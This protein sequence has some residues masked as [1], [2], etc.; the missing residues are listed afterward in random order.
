MSVHTAMQYNYQQYTQTSGPQ[1]PV[2][3]VT[4]ATPVASSFAPL[5]GSNPGQFGKPRFETLEN[6]ATLMSSILAPGGSTP[7]YSQAQAYL[8]NSRNSLTTI[9]QKVARLQDEIPKM[10]ELLDSARIKLSMLLDQEREYTEFIRHFTPLSSPPPPPVEEAH[11]YSSL[12]ADYMPHTQHNPSR[13]YPVVPMTRP[14]IAHIEHRSFNFSPSWTHDL[15]QVSTHAAISSQSK[16]IKFKIDHS[17]IDNLLSTTPTSKQDGMGELINVCRKDFCGTLTEFYRNIDGGNPLFI[18]GLCLENRYGAK[19]VLIC[20]HRNAKELNRFICSTMLNFTAEMHFKTSTLSYRLTTGYAPDGQGTGVDWSLDFVNHADFDSE[21]FDPKSTVRD[22]RAT[23][24]KGRKRTLEKKYTLFF[25]SLEE[26]DKMN[27]CGDLFKDL[28]SFNTHL[29]TQGYLPLPLKHVPESLIMDAF[30]QYVAG[31][32]LMN[33]HKLRRLCEERDIEKGP[34]M[35]LPMSNSTSQPGVHLRKKL[36]KFYP[37]FYYNDVANM[38]AAMRTFHAHMHQEPVNPHEDLVKQNALA[39]LGETL[40]KLFQPAPRSPEEFPLTDVTVAPVFVPPKPVLPPDPTISP[41]S[42]ASYIAH[43]VSRSVNSAVDTVTERAH[44]IGSKFGK[45]AVAGAFDQFKTIIAEAI[46]TVRT[47]LSAGLASLMDTIKANKHLII[48][49]C[50][51]IL[52]AV[53]GFAF[54]KLVVPYWFPPKT[55][56]ILVEAHFDIKDIFSIICGKTAENFVD[57]TKIDGKGVHGSTKDFHTTGFMSSI[58]DASSIV[59]LLMNCDKIAITFASYVKALLDWSATKVTS[60]PFFES[61][62][63]ILNYQDEIKSMIST[64]DVQNYDTL[65]QKREFVKTYERLV[66]CAQVLF[67]IDIPLYAA[68]TNVVFRLQPVF[69]QLKSHICTEMPRQKPLSVWFAGLTGVGKTFAT[70]ELPKALFGWL[71]RNHPESFAEIGMSNYSEGLVL[72]RRF[73]NE[74]W[75]GYIAN[76]HWVVKMDDIFQSYKMEDRGLEA[77]AVISIV[78]DAAYAL[79]MAAIE[80]KASTYFL[81][82]VLLMSSN[83]TEPELDCIGI[84]SPAAFRRRRDFII[85]VLPRPGHLKNAD[86]AFT[87][88]AFESMRF[89]VKQLNTSTM[90]FSQPIVFD[91]LA[92]WLKLVADIGK[93]YVFH[94]D[95]SKH[96]SN[97]I[98]YSNLFEISPEYTEYVDM[99]SSQIKQKLPDKTW[100]P[101]I[102]T[103]EQTTSTTTAISTAPPIEGAGVGLDL[104]VDG[105]MEG[106]NP[107]SNPG[108][109]SKYSGNKVYP[110][111]HEE[112]LKRE[113]EAIRNDIYTPPTR[114]QK[115]NRF[116][117]K[118]ASTIWKNKNPFVASVVSQLMPLPYW[119]LSK[120]PEIYDPIRTTSQVGHPLLQAENFSNYRVAN[121]TDLTLIDWVIDFTPPIL[122]SAEEV[123]QT[124]LSWRNTVNSVLNIPF[125]ATFAEYDLIFDEIRLGNQGHDFYYNV[126][127]WNFMNNPT[128]DH[129]VIKLMTRHASLAECRIVSNGDSYNRKR[130]AYIMS[131]PHYPIAMV[132][133]MTKNTLCSAL[134]KQILHQR[135]VPLVHYK[136]MYNMRI[137]LANMGCPIRT[138]WDTW[139]H[140]APRVPEPIAPI[141]IKKVVQ[142]TSLTLSLFATIAASVLLY[143]G[144]CWAIIQI[145]TMLIVF[146]CRLFGR[147]KK[148]K[149]LIVSGH[150]DEKYQA[151]LAKL[152]RRKTPIIPHADGSD[153]IV[154]EAHGMQSVSDLSS[155]FAYNT[156]LAKF[157]FTTGYSFLGFMSSTGRG[158]FAFPRHY[159]IPGTLRSIE[160]S[161]TV[162]RPLEHLVMVAE[163]KHFIMHEFEDRDLVLCFI[164]GIQ[165]FRNLQSHLRSRK[166]PSLEGVA[167]TARIDILDSDTVDAVFGVVSPGMIHHFTGKRIGTQVLVDGMN[168]PMT[169]HSE[170]LLLS[171]LPSMKK[172]CGLFTMCTNDAIQKKLLGINT[173]GSGD[174]SCT[175]PIY[176]E[177]LELMEQK[178]LAIRSVSDITNIAHCAIEFADPLLIPCCPIVEK[179]CTGFYEGM[180]VFSLIDKAGNFPQKTSLLPTPV[181]T[182]QMRLNE[183]IPPPYEL[184]TAPAKLRTTELIDPL[185]LSFRKEKGR[186]LYFGLD[187]F[188]P[189]YWRG[190]FTE[191]FDDF[192]YRILTLEEAINGI[193]HLGNFHGIALNTASGHPWSQYGYQRS[194]LIVRD[195]PTP[196]VFPY[197][198]GTKPK[199]SMF[200]ERKG[201]I[202]LWVHPDLQTS[203]YMMFYHASLGLVTPAYFLYCL[204]DETRPLDRVNLGY[205]RG[206]AMGSVHH[207]I[208]C[209]MVF[210]LIFSTL[211]KGVDHD[212]CVSV[213]PFSSHWTRI[214]ARL[215]QFG[216]NFVSHDVEAYD[217]NF[218]VQT[219]APALLYNFALTFKLKIFG[220]EYYCL[221]NGT[222]STFTG[223]YVIR[224]I[225]VIRMNQPS[226]GYCTTVYNSMANS[227]KGRR[228]WGEVSTEPF[229]L[230]V[231][232]IVGGDDSVVSV[233]TE[234]VKIFNGIIISKIAKRLF[235]HTHT[236]STKGPVIHPFDEP[237]STV[238]YKRPFT[239]LKGIFIAPLDPVTLESMTQWIQKPRNGESF[240]TQ[241]MTN[242]HNAIH[243][244]ANHSQDDFERHK[245]ILNGFLAIY[246]VNYLY[247]QTFEERRMLISGCVSE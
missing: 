111:S 168:L 48:F 17:T 106:N 235:N 172:K 53:C 190:I 159:L 98:D 70:E 220:F 135:Y 204:K 156:V 76:Q 229:D 189:E 164:P 227:V 151:S 16:L 22:N 58:R 134:V 129:P 42:P 8:H 66:Q 188:P 179:P 95:V 176:L 185:H 192:K 68:A 202:G 120:I 57:S 153:E 124:T 54:V 38:C 81:S 222:Y 174:S 21:D 24:I 216:N 147:E 50:L 167:G 73:E 236:S 218:F 145:F 138:D 45:G 46:S 72:T 60:K 208:Y 116:V 239:H 56:D 122:S 131:L 144:I 87:T 175:A 28:D 55:A 178:V 158:I 94:Y 49:M 183:W 105:H 177:D 203:I 128:I 165:P 160:M 117:S 77:L 130:Y 80:S 43:H 154:V 88:Q 207:L 246:G 215:S 199:A 7:N 64:L 18:V 152:W 99:T 69:L 109:P 30:N 82:K 223:R 240:A 103:P 247:T 79:H 126:P 210:G 11:T 182:G 224:N 37:Y 166:D 195:S 191:Y 221:A 169:R 74:F 241:F 91:G 10:S 238:Y 143:V 136:E 127:R 107:S 78:N 155:L 12:F 230:H 213:N 114:F 180:P 198:L 112:Q 100:K 146:L 234:S 237:L 23:R 93:R 1:I 205:T 226:G 63:Q 212:V 149:K 225:V 187:L 19:A 123:E 214:Y 75:E 170:M 186:R 157:E 51:L 163:S 35:R 206:F 97:P 194:D 233:D 85:E 84:T 65:P 125:F 27:H 132:N 148:G 137:Q 173:A 89:S 62:Q 9:S 119:A 104:L 118:T 196:N 140:I 243:E 71:K 14:S 2:T 110:G 52:I 25:N 150:S 36:I 232:Q 5:Q 181:R 211:E 33:F 59:T 40:A 161:G 108:G 4:S 86:D 245:K 139:F 133:D 47:H 31:H 231:A 102:Y 34:L 193:P 67:K 184:R 142:Y 171:G 32:G 92:G 29:I 197:I 201:E 121:Q 20:S 15:L 209:R 26:P 162:F 219:F 115:F 61:S 90:L 113:N 217:M 228:I 244:W 141:V 41:L 13:P 101:R 6:L 44:D 83:L 96:K 200:T 242:C 3:S 39:S